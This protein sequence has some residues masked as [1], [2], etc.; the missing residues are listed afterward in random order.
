M[1][2]KMIPTLALAFS[3]AMVSCGGSSEDPAPTPP[4]GGGGVSVAGKFNKNVLIEDFTGT[5]CGYCPRVSYAIEQVQSQT[6]K[7]VP[8][9]IHRGNDPYN[10]AEGQILEAQIGLQGYPTAM[11]NRKT[12]WNSPEPSYINQVKNLTGADANLGIALKP[13][14]TNG[15]INLDVKVKFASDMTNLKM[16]VYVLENDLTYNQTNYTSY[17]GGT[18][19]IVGFKHDNVLRATL[20]NIL[21]ETMNGATTN[22]TT[23][24]KTYTAAVPTNITNSA[25]VTFVAFVLDASGKAINSRKASVNDNQSFEEN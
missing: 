11:L 21:G 16:V 10:F 17:Y 20:T 4:T 23:W 9:A 12:T 7:S 13:T 8:V 25:K 22:G 18:A 14:I 5:W 6:T 19:T 1:F 24:T 3:V 15:S 2:K